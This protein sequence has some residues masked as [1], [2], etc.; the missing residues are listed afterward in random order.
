[1]I[2]WLDSGE[3]WGM[4]TRELVVP[5]LFE[6]GQGMECFGGGEFWGREIGG[7]GS[8]FLTGE[9]CTDCKPALHKFVN[10]VQTSEII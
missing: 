9:G 2:E 1:M 5:G 8:G 7:R 3:F 6:W 4:G 10:S